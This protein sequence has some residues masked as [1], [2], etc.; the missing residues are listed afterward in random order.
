M[1]FC[2]TQPRIRKRTGILCDKIFILAYP[3]QIMSLSNF[4]SKLNW[5]LIVTHIAAWWFVRYTLVEFADYNVFHDPSHVLDGPEWGYS[6]TL[7]EV[8]RYTAPVV[9]AIFS[10]FISYRSKQHW[11]NSLIVLLITFILSKN[12]LVMWYPLRELLGLPAAAIDKLWIRHIIDG[13]IMLCG[14]LFLF[15]LKSIT[16]HINRKPGL[17]RHQSV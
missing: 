13:L 17:I 2:T 11:I 10:L 15:F 9:T 1:F 5:R 14:A 16:R 3:T 6:S 8:I 4:I 12:D 7:W